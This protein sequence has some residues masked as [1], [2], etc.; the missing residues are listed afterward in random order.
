MP[1]DR[2][3]VAAE[4]DFRE[5]CSQST[6][7]LEATPPEPQARVGVRAGVVR[8]IHARRNCG[9]ASSPRIFFSLRSASCIRVSTVPSGRPSS[10]E[11]VI[12]FFSSYIRICTTCRCSAGN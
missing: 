6:L 4:C 5:R 3:L 9:Y 7:R 12:N 1:L 8:R 2:R 11:M 10:S